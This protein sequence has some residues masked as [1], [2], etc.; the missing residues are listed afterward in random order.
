MARV[1]VPDVVEVDFNSFT[2]RDIKKVEGMLG[3][4]LGDMFAGGIAGMDADTLAAVVCVVIQRKNPEFTFE[5][6]LDLPLQRI[7]DVT[8]PLRGQKPRS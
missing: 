8:S 4:K 6:A 5:E 7:E 1:D 3:R 2:M